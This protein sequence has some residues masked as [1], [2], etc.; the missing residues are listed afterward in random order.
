MVHLT[1]S[2]F[3]A[4]PQLELVTEVVEVQKEDDLVVQG[5]FEVCQSNNICK[6]PTFN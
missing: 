2:S 6:T 4:Q 1:S 5:T 3:D